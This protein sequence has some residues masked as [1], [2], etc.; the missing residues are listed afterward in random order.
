[1]KEKIKKGA[2]FFTAVLAA[3]IAAPFQVQATSISLGTAGDFNTFIF[4]NFSGNSDTEGRLAVGGDAYLDGYSVGLKIDPPGGPALVVGGNLTL[5]SGHILNGDTHV[6]GTA[7]MPGYDAV[8]NGELYVGS[9]LP[10]NFAAE[11][12]YL[13]NLSSS[14]SQETANGT[15]ELKWGSNLFLNG[16]GESDLQIF[17]VLGSDLLSATVFRI[18]DIPE[19]ATILLNISGNYAGFTNMGF[20]T[21]ENY[22]SDTLF[23]FYQADTLTISGAG[24]MGSILAPRAHIDASNGVING[25]TIGASW[26]GPVQQNHS[27]FTPYTPPDGPAPVPEPATMLLF[28]TGL[29]GMAGSRLKRKMS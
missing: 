26:N 6:G 21:F 29:A 11:A 3:M 28:G 20:I 7:N 4:E 12:T 10:I 14:L 18:N 17:N 1:M 27:L 5:T 8:D 16:D 15:N 19:D 13:T 25:T 9:Q 23:N 24:V 2:W 22:R